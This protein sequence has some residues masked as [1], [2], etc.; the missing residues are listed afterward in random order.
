MWWLLSQFCTCLGR[1]KEASLLPEEESG[2]GVDYGYAV[3]KNE[4]A[5]ME[6]AIDVKE[7]VAGYR[8]FAVYDG[9][10]GSQAVMVAKENLP[11]ILESYLKDAEDVE[12]AI[13]AAFQA[14]D[15]EIMQV[16]VDNKVVADA[17]TSSGTVACLGLLKKTDLWIANLGDCRAVVS[18][19]GTAAAISR[20]HA[21][22]KNPAEAERL[23]QSGVSV[24]AGYVDEH[25]AVSRA[26]GNVRFRTGSKVNGIINEPEVFRVEIDDAVD[27]VMI[28][29]D[30]IWDALKE[31][32]A[33]THA[34]KALRTTAKPE[35]AAVSILQNA[36]RVS[37]AD[38]AAVVVIVFKFPEPLPKR[39][40]V[41][42]VSLTQ[43]QEPSA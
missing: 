24:Q 41:Q 26:L 22:E 16:L 2:G 42:R 6:D 35:D 32:F 28:G 39:P 23:Q 20:D 11:R 13:K 8:L 14:A 5:N 34:R 38:N 40:A 30:G 3:A 4:R 27:F 25:V 43:L 18:K 36:G 17:Q 21:P 37:K 9:H 29:S 1:D 33:L 31:Q 10:A 7:D 12:V 19:D 15:E